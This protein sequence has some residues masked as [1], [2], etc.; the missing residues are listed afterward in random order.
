[1]K[2]EFTL[3][4]DNYLEYQNYRLQQRVST[5]PG[6]VA[7]LG[8]G[9]V[10]IGY[11]LLRQG[12]E[13]VVAGMVLFAG[14]ATAAASVPI[15]ISAS[16]LQ[17]QDRKRLEGLLRRE[18]DWARSGPRVFGADESGWRFSYKQAEDVRTWADLS[19][20]RDE[21][22]TFLMA[23]DL[24]V[25]MVPKSALIPEELEQ[26]RDFCVR[27]LSAVREKGQAG[28]TCSIPM[29]LTMGDVR[30]AAFSHNWHKQ[31]RK[32]LILYGVGLLAVAF[33][34]LVLTDAWPL[35][36]L[37]AA[38]LLP[39]LLPSTE[40]LY[41]SI[42][43]QKGRWTNPFQVATVSSD[44]LCLYT[45][46]LQATT[47][48][49]KVTPSRIFEV[50]ETNRA[51]MIYGLPD[52]FYIIPKSAIPRDKLREIRDLFFSINNVKQKEG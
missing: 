52:L 5:L 49:F 11:I 15:A 47:A 20:F 21:K 42:Q 6:V 10:A 1:M 28:E 34:W 25:Y 45:G 50:R 22:Q 38:F 24:V 23:D 30:A 9:L 8:F 19:W 17:R 51:F 27:S 39:L 32:R 18:F 48:M 7:L 31:L 3:T 37:P 2:I 41:Y 46:T 12:C 43:F 26:L 13:G 35:L 4:F 14:L 40:A 44:A 36:R 33:V 29:A 16:F